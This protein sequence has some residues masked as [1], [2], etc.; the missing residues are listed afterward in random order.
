MKSL[1]ITLKKCS[2]TKLH[3]WHQL[4]HSKVIRLADTWSSM[5]EVAKNVSLKF[6]REIDYGETKL[7]GEYEAFLQ[8]Y[9]CATLSFH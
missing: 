1:R 8:K 5:H 4:Q 9:P 7:K 6:R 2:E 3:L